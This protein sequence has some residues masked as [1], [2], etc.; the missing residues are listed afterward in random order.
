MTGVLRHAASYAQARALHGEL[1]QAAA[2][3]TL[4]RE[5]DVAGIAR[6]LEDG[7][8][9]PEVPFDPAG[10]ERRLK[11]RLAAWTARMTALQWGD[12]KELLRAYSR[13]FELANLKIVLRGLVHRLPRARVT[14]L[15]LPLPHSPLKWQALLDA[16]SLQGVADQLGGTPYQRPLHTVLEQQGEASLFPFE[17][18]LDLAY[19]QALV[20]RIER[21]GGADAR[22]AERYL[23]RWI[24]VENLSWAFRYRR[25]A[26]LTPEETIN[27]TL[28][29]AFGAGLDAVR[30]VALGASVAEE[31]ERLGL[32][33]D[34][35]LT[36]DDALTLLELAAARQRSDAASRA[37][38]GVLFDLGAV[39]A[40]LTLREA[41]VR[42]LVTLV[43]ARRS[44]VADETLRARWVS[45]A[46]RMG[47]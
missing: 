2:W 11:S 5:Q 40:L 9:G 10:L 25:L 36:E 21:L 1:L 33:V 16:G 43:E 20:R 6:R 4:R 41:E 38:Q 32:R 46:A 47:R 27:Y 15:L 44:G 12:P 39:L 8:Y 35:G 18:A 31:A 13:R 45:P 37:F 7:P 30:R 26:G 3:R 29:R 14:A 24:A 28:H 34:P 19:L 17:V 23:G 42:D 22:A